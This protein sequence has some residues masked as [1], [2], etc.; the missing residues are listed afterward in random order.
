[1]RAGMLLSVL[2]GMRLVRAASRHWRI[3]LGL[4]GLLLEILGH[5]ALAGQVRTAAGLLGLVLVLTAALKSTR[6]DA[7]RRPVMPQ[8]AWRWHG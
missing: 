1:M 7:D 2:G 4:G 5:F 3:S 8:T 6:P